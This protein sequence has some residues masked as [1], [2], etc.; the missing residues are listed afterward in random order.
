MDLETGAPFRRPPADAGSYPA[1]WEGVPPAWLR[2]SAVRTCPAVF[3]TA[4]WESR[5]WFD[6]LG[7]MFAFRVAPQPQLDWRLLD[8]EMATLAHQGRA[9]LAT[10]GTPMRRP[11]WRRLIQPVP[12]LTD[13]VNVSVQPFGPGLVA[14]T[15]T[16]RQA[17]IDTASLAVTGWVRYDDEL[18]SK[19]I[20]SAHPLFDAER[21]LVLNIAQVFGPRPECVLYQHAPGEFRRQVVGRWRAPEL[22][23]VHAFG[24]TPRHAVLIGHPLLV[25]PARMLFSD[26]AFIDHFQWQPERGTRLVVFDRAGGSPRIVETDT[27]FVFHVANAFDEGESVVLDV[28]AYPDPGIVSDLRTDRLAGGTKRT[29]DYVRIRIPRQG[30]ATMERHLSPGF[31]FPAINYRGVAGR[32]HRFCWGADPWASKSGSR[33]FKLDV[34]RRQAR[35]ISFDDWIVGEPLFVPAPEAGAED[36]GVLLAVGSHATR[37][38]A[39]LFVIDAATLDV[40]AKAE[41]PVSVP[42]GFHGTF[43]QA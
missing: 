19:A 23:Y 15:E 2:G 42:L 20:M 35:E 12:R 36:A 26:R 40:V 21:R 18:G 24:L 32:A 1:Q 3:H 4:N 10:F 6:G 16:N 11:W 30:R 22:P 7:A 14:M 5:H 31:E 38:A 43:L 39:A 25:R 17:Q 34:E 41:A 33:V 9:V 37:D 28:L 13:N 27:C 8:C 29:P